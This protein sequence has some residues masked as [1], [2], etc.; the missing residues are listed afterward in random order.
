MNI[1][2]TGGTGFL[3]SHLVKRLL[4]DKHNQVTVVTTS[5]RVNNSMKLLN[6]DETSLNIV[7]GDIRNFEFLRLLFNE[8]EFDTVY[9][10]G[11]VSEVRKCQYDAKLAF[12]VNV[13]GTVNVLE[14]CRL[15]NNIKAIAISSSD[16]AYGKAVNLPY[17]EDSSL[18]GTGIYE[19]SKS[20]VDLISRSYHYNYG[21]PIVVTRCS[22]LYGGGDAN[23][24]R[25]IPNNIRKILN[26]ESP[27]IWK[28]CENDVREFLYVEDAVEAYISLVSNIDVVKGNAYNI[29]SGEKVTIEELIKL[30][31][32]KIDNSIEI[33]YKDK[34]FPEISL[35]YLDS[36]KIKNDV[37]WE[38]KVM[39]NDGLDYTIR[40]YMGLE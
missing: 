23:F 22:N 8:Y 40:Q 29:G 28:G 14:M 15:Y 26:G 17:T 19:V 13:S 31:L 11:A 35:Q 24:T 6:I 16:K 39:L 7:E 30:L 3:G 27:V 37:G 21:L 9:H 36:T 38:A 32:S 33:E 1:L 10:L 34:D 20:C 2:V 4:K 25:V 5:I 18:S 12:D